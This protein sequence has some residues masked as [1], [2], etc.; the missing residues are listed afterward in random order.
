LVDLVDIARC[1]SFVI[2]V[3]CP[4][5]KTSA[6]VGFEAPDDPLVIGLDMC[7]EIWFEIF[8]ADILKTLRDN[9]TREIVLQKK[10]LPILFLEFPVL[11]LNPFLI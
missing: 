5:N 4:L 7:S 6:V 8:D 11:L 3:N 9:M 2:S 10:Y 1:D